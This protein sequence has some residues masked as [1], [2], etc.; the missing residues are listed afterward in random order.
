MSLINN[1]HNIR[2]HGYIHAIFANTY[3]KTTHSIDSDKRIVKKKH[4][5]KWIYIQAIQALILPPK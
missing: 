5:T 3:K 2:T 1:S 4:E